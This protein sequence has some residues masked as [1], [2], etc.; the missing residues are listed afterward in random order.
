VR[1]ARWKYVRY[2]DLEGMD[3][4]YDL[5]TD[6]MEMRNLINEPGARTELENLRKELDR[7]RKEVP[8]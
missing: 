8:A 2:F 3:E 6:S 4:M 5:Q 1:T 7:Y